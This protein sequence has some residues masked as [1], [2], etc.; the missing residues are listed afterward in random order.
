MELQLHGTESV[1]CVTRTYCDDGVQGDCRTRT[2]ARRRYRTGLAIWISCSPSPTIRERA[3]AAQ[4]R[5]RAMGTARGLPTGRRRR[6]L[7]SIPSIGCF[8]YPIETSTEYSSSH[9]YTECGGSRP[10]T[11]GSPPGWRHDHR[12][13]PS[14]LMAHCSAVPAVQCDGR[15]RA[16]VLEDSMQWTGMY[17][18]PCAWAKP[19]CRPSMPSRFPFHH[20]GFGL[21]GV[22]ECCTD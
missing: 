9:L 5:H 16:G 19:V 18:A 21:V 3:G 1:H 13:T 20:S 12:S 15:C 11:K 14:K 2:V 17:A 4:H 7:R 22:L 6:M 8:S 10:R